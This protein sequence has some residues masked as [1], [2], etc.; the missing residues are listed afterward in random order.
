M[1]RVWRPVMLAT[2]LLAVP[3]CF[4]LLLMAPKTTAAALPDRPGKAVYVHRCAGCHALI[5]P[6]SFRHRLGDVV[7]HYRDEKI[8]TASEQRS[9]FEY[10]STF[11]DNRG[12]LRPPP[13]PTPTPEVTPEP[14]PSPAVET[15]ESP[16][17]PTSPELTPSG[18]TDEPA[19]P[20]AS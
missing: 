15:P 2:T 11:P 18:N 3:G 13:T 16:P 1:T 14:T 5:E 4:F 6:T 8:I 20:E 10:L 17:A 19:P 7:Y 12:R 9:L